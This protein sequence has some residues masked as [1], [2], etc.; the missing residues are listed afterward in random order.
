MNKETLARNRPGRRI[1]QERKTL[2]NWRKKRA[3]SPEGCL[4]GSRV[5]EEKNGLLRL[6][7]N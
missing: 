2:Q 5:A 1:L 6:R 4:F 3:G 7:K